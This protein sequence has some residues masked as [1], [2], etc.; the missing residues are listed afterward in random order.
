MA[1]DVYTGGDSFFGYR[2]SLEALTL[3]APLLLL[4]YTSWVKHR[5]QLKRPLLVALALSVSLQVFGAVFYMP[6]L[7]RWGAPL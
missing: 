2:I 3:W 7:E 1:L 4:S 6:L 5:P